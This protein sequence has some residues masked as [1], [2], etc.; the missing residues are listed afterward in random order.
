M[1][2]VLDTNVWISAL[3]FSRQDGTVYRA[4]ERAIGVDTIA[5]C[6]EMEEEI[7]RTLRERFSW[8]SSR[9]DAV[10]PAMLGNAI[11]VTISG[12]VKICRDPKDDMILECSE[13]ANARVIVTGDKDLL[14]LES[15]KLSRIVNPASYLE[16]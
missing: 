11:S 3:Q 1:I 2:V 7:E 6:P 5:I 13:R 12:T 16:M 9:I 4:L 15:Y 14:A 10:L 8:P